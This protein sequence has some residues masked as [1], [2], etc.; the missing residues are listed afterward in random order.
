[1]NAHETLIAGT[2]PSA[3][4]TDDMAMLRAAT[5]LTRDINEA[6]PEIYWP[7]ML[8]SA[9]LGYAALASAMLLAN[10]GSKANHPAFAFQD[11]NGS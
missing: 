7:D 5:A 8:L 3:G 6:R 9:A 10:H 4:I 2:S 11:Q 1:M